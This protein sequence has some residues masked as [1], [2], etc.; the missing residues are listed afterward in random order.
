M[1]WMV[2]EV[3]V[4]V[5]RGVKLLLWMDVLIVLLMWVNIGCAIVVFLQ[6]VV[7]YVDFFCCFLRSF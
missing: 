3:C 2:V 4:V 5:V 6:F 7:L 1:G